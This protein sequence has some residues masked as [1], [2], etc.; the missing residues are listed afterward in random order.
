MV[1]S[2]QT[3][4]ISPVPDLPGSKILPSG[5]TRRRRSISKHRQEEDRALKHR[6]P[7]DSPER[8]PS[9]AQDPER[10]EAVGRPIRATPP[11]RSPREP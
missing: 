7:M 4:F 1:V 5:P 11:G 10:L 2:F 3:D 8:G 9:P 6:S